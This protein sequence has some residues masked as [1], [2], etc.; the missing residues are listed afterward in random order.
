MSFVRGFYDWESESIDSSLIYCTLIF[1]HVKGLPVRK[2][3]G[4]NRETMKAK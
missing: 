4:N 1:P 3:Y 2:Y